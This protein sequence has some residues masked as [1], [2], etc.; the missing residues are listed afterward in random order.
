MSP[1]PVNPY[2]GSKLITLE[3]EK[4]TLDQ[5]E[6]ILGHDFEITELRDG[7][8]LAFKTKRKAKER[9]N[10]LATQLLVYAGLGIKA[11]G[12]AVLLIKAAASAK[13]G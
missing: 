11:F 9:P 6:V 10:A 7:E 13:L 12:P 8:K 5:L 2:S 4:V 3:H 1:T